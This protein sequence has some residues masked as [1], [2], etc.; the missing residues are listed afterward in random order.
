MRFAGLTLVSVLVLVLFSMTA[1]AASCPLC[2]GKATKSYISI[3]IE[4]Q[5]RYVGEIITVN[6]SG[7][8]DHVAE[9]LEGEEIQI[10][11]WEGNNISKKSVYTDKNG[12]GKF[13]P[14]DSWYYRLNVNRQFMMIKV[15]PVCGDGRCTTT[16]HRVNCPEDCASCGDG[17]CD[18]VETAENCPKDCVIGED[19]VCGEEVRHGQRPGAKDVLQILLGFTSLFY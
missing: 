11:Y 8:K 15:L 9:P 10:E 5:E 18:T 6:V 14:V 7:I 12:L 16:E 13:V 4:P 17:I 3:K 1:Q 19:S 2:Q